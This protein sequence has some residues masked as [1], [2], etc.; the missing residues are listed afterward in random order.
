MFPCHFFHVKAWGIITAG[1]P[2]CANLALGG[3]SAAA[4]LGVRQPGDEEGSRVV[5]WLFFFNVCCRLLFLGGSKKGGVF[6][7]QTN[8]S[9][10]LFMTHF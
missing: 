5:A 8:K 3:Q 1:P 2:G 4:D 9:F 7:G 6:L 10:L